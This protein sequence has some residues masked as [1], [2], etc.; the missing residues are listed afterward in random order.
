MRFLP[1]AL[2]ASLALT[3][4]GCSDD[5]G[6][7]DGAGGDAGEATSSDAGAGPSK[8]GSGA[9]GDTTG[10]T[11]GT[12]G[13]GDAEF[14]DLPGKIRFINFVSDGMAGINLDLYWGMTLR[15][16]E[17]VGTVEYGEITDYFTPRH[18]EDSILDPDEARFFMVPEGDV[19]GMPTSFVIQDEISFTADTVL[20]IGLAAT[21][22]FGGNLAV[23]QRIIYEHELSTP[24]AGVAHVYE[25]SNAF[26]QIEDASFVVVAADGLCYP[27]L[28]DP[29]DAN[30]GAP[31]L[32]PEGTTGVSLVDAN[33]EPP[34]ATG[35]PPVTESIEVGHSYV[36]LGEAE[37]YDAAARRAVFLE[38]TTTN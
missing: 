4:A 3:F 19:S 18:P 20:T 37:T 30:L 34:C 24:P 26:A 35:T 13:T 29:G 32:I 10:P 5:D 12:I 23:S 27:D 14:T 22:S 16:S 38:L 8:G 36:L 2:V 21:D 1:I 17:L 33:T 9:A 7:P 28:G 6:S 25:W 11:G 31:A 15:T